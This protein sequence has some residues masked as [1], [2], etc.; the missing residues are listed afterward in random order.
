VALWGKKSAKEI[1][2]EHFA[3]CRKL[4]NGISPYSQALNGPLEQAIE[5]VPVA[6]LRR[7]D[8][9]QETAYEIMNGMLPANSPSPTD[10]YL[11]YIFSHSM[12]RATAR[13]QILRHTCVLCGMNAAEDLEGILHAALASH[14]YGFI[15]L[16]GGSQLEQLGSEL[17][18]PFFNAAANAL[19]IMASAEEGS[20]LS[21]I[22]IA[23][24]RTQ[25]QQLLPMARE[26]CANDGKKAQ[27]LNQYAQIVEAAGG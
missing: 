5:A 9:T 13:A 11:R 21:K 19:R 14:A 17:S 12:Y 6:D 25:F 4:C 15:H 18:Y 26:Q 1:G 7:L 27:R 23:M 3:R 22:S 24:Q 8:D 10:I 16:T 2:E 20:E